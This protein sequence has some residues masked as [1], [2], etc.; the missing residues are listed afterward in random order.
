M[1]EDMLVLHADKSGLPGY[2]MVWY[3]IIIAGM[4]S[5]LKNRAYCKLNRG[6]KKKLPDTIS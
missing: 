1:I 5:I 4:Q 6:T 2:L 3:S